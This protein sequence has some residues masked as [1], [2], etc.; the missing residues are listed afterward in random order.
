MVILFENIYYATYRMCNFISNLS[1]SMMWSCE[2]GKQGKSFK[3]ESLMF[4]ATTTSF[5]VMQLQ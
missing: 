1:A 4:Y 5:T 3:S 2:V